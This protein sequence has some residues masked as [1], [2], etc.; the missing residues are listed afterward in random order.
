MAIPLGYV[1]A[2]SAIAGVLS[3]VGYFMHGEHMLTAPLL[4][5]VAISG[6]PIIVVLVSNLAGLSISH[7]A[8]PTS[9]GYLAYMT[10]LF[11]S[12]LIYR[13]FFHPLHHFPG[14]KLARLSQFY[15]FFCVRAKVDNY[16]HLDRLHDQY[17]EYVRAGPNLL[18]ISDPDLIE[19]IFHPHSS[20]GKADWYDIAH[21]VTNLV[22]MRDR[23]E[24]DR[25]RRHGWD[26]AFTT[27]ALRAYDS[28]VLKY[29]DQFISQM[30]RRSGQSVNVT[31]WLEWF[32]FDVMGDLA[33]GRSFG[34][35]ERGQSHLYIDTMHETSPFPLGCLGSLPWA[36]QVMTAL[37]PNRL[38][39]F[40]NLVRY[41]TEC[42]EER[43]Q[44]KPMEPDIMTPI[45][46]CGPFYSDPKAD[47]LL[48]VGDARLIIIAGSDTSA[49][50]LTHAF[51]NLA[52]DRSIVQRIREELQQ[53]QICNGNS[54]SVTELQHL[55]YLN[56]FINETLRMYPT[57]PS[58]LYRLTP[59]EGT[60]IAGHF[61]P[62]GVK[63]ISPHYTVLR[64]PKAFRFPNEFIPERWTTRP[65]LVLK[66][67]AFCPFS[68]GR[69]SC[70]GKNLA[71]NELRTVIS[72]AVLEFDISFA[73]GETGQA[74]LEESK[75]MFTMALAKLDLRFTPRL[76]E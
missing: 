70:I 53:H 14:P 5:V 15:H 39:P 26:L 19:V 37:V 65:D 21:P 34:A 43:K 36:V 22:Q 27:K 48:L 6:P 61:L 57:N 71:L 35:L 63:L 50:T 2:L 38:N 8:R 29:A 18:S 54:F 56:A 3:H 41:S 25:R 69:F 68:L 67:K 10:A 30:H 47:A 9:V 13:A 42:I 4:V 51:Y 44:R 59:P 11:T 12:I 7:A 32:A 16:K 49:S 60:T 73:P 31:N 72:K 64:S 23:A 62:G 24:H 20:F 33:F 46:A 40:M 66:K 17:G 52:R 28:R 1:A 58:G 45:L 76:Y 55:E 74:L 75:D